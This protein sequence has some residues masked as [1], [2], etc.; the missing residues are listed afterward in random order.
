MLN[1]YLLCNTEP[2]AGLS[3]P[4]QCDGTGKIERA[5]RALNGMQLKKIL[6]GWSGRKSL[7]SRTLP[8][9]SFQSFN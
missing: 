7:G 1:L 5:H 2:H 3:L 9:Y 4:A 6:H 8:E